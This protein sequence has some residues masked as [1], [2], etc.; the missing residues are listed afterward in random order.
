MHTDYAYCLSWKSTDASSL[1][2]ISDK[3]MKPIKILHHRQTYADQSIILQNFP[4]FKY[5]MTFK[6]VF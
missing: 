5:K 1:A 2:R 3:R 4:D 6:F